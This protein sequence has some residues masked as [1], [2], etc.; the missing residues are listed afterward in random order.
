MER[1]IDVIR[2]CHII[3]GMGIGGAETMLYNIQKYKNDK[4]LIHTVIS[5]QNKGGM[6]E[7][8]ND[9]GLNYILL[10]LKKHPLKSIKKII[11]TAKENE[12]LSCW[13]YHSNLVGYVINKFAKCKKLIW[14]IRH[15][16]IDKDKNSKSMLICNWF[17][18]KWSKKVDI[19]AYNGEKSRSIHEKYGYDNSKSVIMINGCDT[20][21][22]NPKANN[23]QS[24]CDELKINNS[25]KIILS[26]ARYNILKDFP[27]FI[28]II[29]EIKGNAVGVMCGKN[30]NTNNKQLM[31]CIISNQL[32]MD[33]DIF[34]LDERKDI[35]RIMASSDI[36]V[37]HS[38]GGEAFPN[39]IIQA[40]SSGVLVVSTDAGIA[41]III[42]DDN[43]V[44]EAGNHRELANNVV[45]TL[46]LSDEQKQRIVNNHRIRVLENYNIIQIVKN[47][48]K[49]Y[50]GE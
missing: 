39:T 49:L 16:S 42:D 25:K 29:R 6:I 10:D 27:A 50:I 38:S 3:T 2:V 1:N 15:T 4:N 24:L 48:E 26:V 35:P 11:S 46:E 32:M 36:Y 47:Y 37:M 9:S 33:K 8:Y 17:C 20:D 40:M 44:S 22:Y 41:R 18:K 30:V 12:V 45:K 28:N 14:N 5:L 31:E 23:K 21:L 7:Q 34:L 43:F 13:M 19:I